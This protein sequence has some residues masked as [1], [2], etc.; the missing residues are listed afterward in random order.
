MKKVFIVLM[1]ISLFAAC[2]DDKGSKKADYRE[3]D[4]YSN[5]DGKN[6]DD[7]NQTDE[8]SKK[9]D[10]QTDFTGGNGWTEED[11]TSFFKQCMMGFGNNLELGKKVCPCALQKFAA[12]YS[13]YAEADKAPESEG[14][15]IGQDCVRELNLDPGN[16]NN[17]INNDDQGDYSNGGWSSGEVKKFVRDCM[18]AAMKNGMQ[19]LDAQ[20]YCDCV[21]DQIAKIYPTAAAADRM[22]QA[23]LASP[24]IQSIINGCKPGN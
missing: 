17:P 11:K 7:A 18:G 16:N 1:A 3:K 9:D 19:E 2:K 22:T 20:S 5:T 6:D 8:K 4:D 14:R 21:Q 24:R 10:N 23:D 12:K 13:S 15:K